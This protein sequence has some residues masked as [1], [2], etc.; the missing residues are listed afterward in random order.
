M[1]TQNNSIQLWTAGTVLKESE[2]SRSYIIKNAAPLLVIIGLG[3]VG[4]IIKRIEFGKE[5]WLY[6]E[7]D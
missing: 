6:A 4:W 1:V 7:G 3:G 2:E 5:I